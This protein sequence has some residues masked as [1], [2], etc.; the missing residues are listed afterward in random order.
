MNKTKTLKWLLAALLLT[1]A[2]IQFIPC[3][4]RAH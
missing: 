4:C 1:M 2:I 3:R